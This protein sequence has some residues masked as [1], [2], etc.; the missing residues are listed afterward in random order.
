M[1]DKNPCM[2]VECAGESWCAVTCTAGVLGRK[3]HPVIVHRLLDEGELG[4][5]DLKREI[6]GITSKVLSESLEDLEAKGILEREIVQ[7][8]PVRVSYYLT[9]VGEG[10]RDVIEAMEA[11]GQQHLEPPEDQEPDARVGTP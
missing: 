1:A 8:K 10:L 5:N 4:F 7:E 9:P 3:W 6:D 2:T 11:W